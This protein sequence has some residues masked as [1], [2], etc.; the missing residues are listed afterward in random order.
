MK[1]KLCCRSKKLKT[2]KKLS[3]I[4]KSPCICIV[5]IILYYKYESINVGM[6]LYIYI[7]INPF[8]DGQV[9]DK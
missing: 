1:L 8:K 9:H 3:M 7:L 6:I 5:Y 2:S 4:K